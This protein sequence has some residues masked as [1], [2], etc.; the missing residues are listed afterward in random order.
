MSLLGKVLYSQGK[1][2][3]ALE[4]SRR[5]TQNGIAFDGAGEA[6]V[7][8]GGIL[9]KRGDRDGSR[10]V[11]RKAA[12]EADDA[13]AYLYLSDFEPSGSNTQQ[14]YLLKAASSGIVEAWHR[15][16]ELEL[17]KLD[18]ESDDGGDVLRSDLQDFGMAREWFELAAV[19]GYGPSMLRMAS[20]CRSGSRVDE[21]W[22][23]LQKAEK[24]PDVADRARLIR[25]Q[26]ELA[27]RKEEIS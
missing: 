27:E 6:L 4:W 12:L 7:Y 1:D 15:L 17:A 9:L 20:M 23:W 10:A 22:T 8:E 2:S 5:A 24:L 14:V 18:S 26:W 19:E 3:E 16:G 13:E 21:G 25:N 11:F